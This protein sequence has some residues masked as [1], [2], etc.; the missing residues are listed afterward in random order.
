MTARP[1]APTVTP[2]SKPFWDGCTRGE[3]LLQRCSDCGTLRHPP[4]PGCPHCR[5]AH[6]E[7]IPA[8]GRGTVYT[9]TIVRQALGKG[10]DEHVPYVVAVIDLA[11]GVR[12][13]SNVVAIAP[14]AVAIGMPVVVVF[15]DGLPLFQ[16]LAG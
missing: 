1:I 3:L 12:M 14:E 16:P 9:F 2:D 15:A 7:W 10:W 13:L 5:S 8:S 11:E 6:S 4:S